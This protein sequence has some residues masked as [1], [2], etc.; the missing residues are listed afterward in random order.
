MGATHRL[1]NLPDD[2]L[3]PSYNSRCHIAAVAADWFI[4]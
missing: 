3:H 4:E 2:G 1:S